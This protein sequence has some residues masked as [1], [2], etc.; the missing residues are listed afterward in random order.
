MTAAGPTTT[1]PAITIRDLEHRFGDEGFR[2]AIDALEVAR[3]EQAAIIGPSGCGKSTLLNLVAGIL[4]PTR[5]TLRVLGFD[6][7]TASDASRR[8]FRRARIGLVFQEFELLEHLPVEE[9]VRLPYLVGSGLEDR[10]T[11]RDRA[12]E[13]LARAGIASHAMKPP[14]ALSQGERQRVAVCRALVTAPDLA[15]ADEPTGNLDAKNARRVVAMLRE[16]CRS[17]GATLLVVTH[18]R[19]LLPEFDRVIDLERYCGESPP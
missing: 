9:N 6:L 14:R 11:S 1:D 13:L 5:G 17:R 19:S 15:L 16:E 12:R 10:A 4:T 2:L 18:D 3:G 8:A 7:T